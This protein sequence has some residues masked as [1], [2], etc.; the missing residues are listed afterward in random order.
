MRLA[1]VETPN[2]RDAP[3]RP[4]ASA[5]PSQARNQRKLL[6]GRDRVTFMTFINYIPICI[7]YRG[8]REQEK[9]IHYPRVLC[10]L[11]LA[12]PRRGSETIPRQ[13]LAVCSQKLLQIS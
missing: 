4:Q 10:F 11:S 12:P 2:S 3:V 1:R 6:P 5:H 7:H 13:Q 8:E 9:G